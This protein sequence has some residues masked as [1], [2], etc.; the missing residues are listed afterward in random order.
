M[1][2][3]YL[4]MKPINQSKLLIVLMLIIVPLAGEPQ[5]HPFGG[6]FTNFRVSFGSPVFLIFLL[7]LRQ[8]SRLKL[9]LAA[10]VF[11]CLFRA[12]LDV[13]SSGLPFDLALYSHA[14]TFFYYFI[15]AVCFALPNLK[16]KAIYEQ[17]IAITFWAILAEIAASIAELSAMNL[18]LSDQIHLLTLPMLGR[19]TF[20]AFLRCFFILS[21][22]FLFQLYTTEARLQRRT[23]EKDRLTT[24]ISGLYEEAFELRATLKTAEDVTHDCYLLY[25]ELQQSPDPARQQD[26]RT[27]LMIAGKVHDLKKSHQRIYAGLQ[28]LTVNR[29]VDDYLPLEKILQL[30]IYAQTKYAKAQN[31]FISF[32][33]TV[34][35]KLPPLHAFTMLSILNNLCANAVEA[36]T[37]Q[38]RIDVNCERTKFNRLRIRF[39]NSGSA[40]PKRRLQ[41]VFRPGYTTKF[42]SSGKASSGVG[43]TYV[44]H[45]IESMGGTITVDSDGVSSVTFT[46][47]VPVFPMQKGVP[48]E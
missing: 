32:N 27:I 22:F 18:L 31:K 7:L 17:A 46:I 44:Q 12:G 35:K 8:Y 4:F 48:R 43:L 11:V 47:E 28:E 30:M 15:Y 21:F 19:I 13:M 40:I 41:N 9:G 42:D 14:P 36:I 20:I 6:E 23:K 37:R 33:Y 29:H 3:A 24:L 5:F 26:A 45:Q 16:S 1:T 10:G 25:D 34:D 38:G 2:P 39:Y